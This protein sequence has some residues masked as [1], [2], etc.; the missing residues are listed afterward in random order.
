MTC[1]TYMHFLLDMYL[2]VGI[3]YRSWCGHRSRSCESLQS[4]LSLEILK[5]G[6]LKVVHDL[7]CH[8]LECRGS[9]RHVECCFSPWMASS[10]ATHPSRLE[11][12]QERFRLHFQHERASLSFWT[13]LGG[14]NK[15]F[16]YVKGRWLLNGYYIHMYI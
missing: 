13:L 16:R 3:H 5:I 8:N 15:S 12:I 14:N 11:S 7:A 2:N 4:S 6:H 10:R 1:N 9:P